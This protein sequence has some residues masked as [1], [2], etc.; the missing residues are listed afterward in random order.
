V[1]VE[2]AHEKTPMIVSIVADASAV[3]GNV[4]YEAREAAAAISQ[5]LE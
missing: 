3:L 4:I 1:I 5:L 2:V